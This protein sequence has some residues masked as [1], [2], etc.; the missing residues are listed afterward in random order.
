MRQGREADAPLVDTVC[1]EQRSKI[2]GHGKH[3]PLQEE[4]AE[5]LSVVGRRSRTKR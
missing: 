3:L 1:T 5:G 2:R 4:A